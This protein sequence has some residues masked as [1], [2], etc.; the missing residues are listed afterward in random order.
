MEE[1]AEPLSWNGIQ[2]GE[3]G[4]ELGNMCFTIWDWPDGIGGIAAS[5][6]NSKRACITSHCDEQVDDSFY[7]ADLRP[8]IDT[9]SLKTRR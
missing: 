2:Q 8:P 4:E 7:C 6:M 9:L 3:D 1:K 5:E